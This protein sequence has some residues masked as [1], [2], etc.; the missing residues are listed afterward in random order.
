MNK[1]DVIQINGPFGFLN[2]PKMIVVE[3]KGS[4]VLLEHLGAKE[5]GLLSFTNRSWHSIELLEEKYLS[6]KGEE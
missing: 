1:G 6:Q 3:I 4:R 2:S 5:G